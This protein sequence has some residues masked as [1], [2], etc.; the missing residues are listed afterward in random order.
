MLVKIC[1]VTRLEDAEYAVACGASAVGFVFWRESPRFIEPKRAGAIVAA[2]PP[3]VTAVGVFVNQPS[4]YVNDAATAAQLGVVQLH[5]DESLAYVSEIMRPVLKA[6]AL[7]EAN[8]EVLAQWP[9]RTTLLV[10]A[11]D[12]VRRGGTG[13]TVDWDRAARVA[14]SRRIVLAGGLTPANVAEAIARVRPFGIDVSSG[15]ESA[16]GVKDHA[17]VRALFEAV[18]VAELKNCYA[19]NDHTPRS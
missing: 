17:R 10:D 19:T 1:G 6:V 2:L 5:G 7:S 15:I 18:G 13:R 11:H 3:F 12:P 4:A 14:R 8:D 9:A 16:P